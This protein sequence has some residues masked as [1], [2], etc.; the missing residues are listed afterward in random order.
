M[1][2]QS[3][4]LTITP[5]VLLVTAADA[6]RVY[7]AANPTMSDTITGFVNGETLATSDLTGTPSNSTTATL[8]SK[9]GAYPITSTV[10]TLKSTDYTFSFQPGT[11]TVTPALLT[12]AA[13]DA[14]RAYG[15]SNPTLPYTLTG[16]ANGETAATGGVT[17]SP[18]FSTIALATSPVGVIR[19]RSPSARAP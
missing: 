8:T 3:A 12:V 4:T 5:V 1:I 14:T 11:L 13:V 10:G 9:V 7:G 19:I 18:L 6:T 15:I 16:F 2:F 17:G